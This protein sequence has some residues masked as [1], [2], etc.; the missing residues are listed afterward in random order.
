MLQVSSGTMASYGL[1][2][3]VEAVKNCRA[4]TKR[5]MKHNNSLPKMSGESSKVLQSRPQ[6]F[7]VDL[8]VD[9]ETYEV[10]ADGVLC[11]APPATQVALGVAQFVF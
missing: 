1:K 11:D 9:P 6:G 4:I 8:T 7:N 10:K 2:K 3:R 5:D